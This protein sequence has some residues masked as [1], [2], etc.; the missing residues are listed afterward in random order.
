MKVL[1]PAALAR[2]ARWLLTEAGPGDWTLAAVERLV[3]VAPILATGADGDNRGLQVVP[4]GD[5]EARFSCGRRCRELVLPVVVLPAQERTAPTLAASFRATVEVLEAALGPATSLGRHGPTGPWFDGSPAWGAP[6]LGW[7]RP[8][9]RTLQLRATD[10]GTVLVLQPTGPSEPWR[11]HAHEWSDPATVGG[12]VRERN[13]P[14]NDDLQTPAAPRARTW[15]QWQA[16]LAR[17]LAR[18]PAETMATGSPLHFLMVTGACA[19]LTL[20]STTDGRL[21]FMAGLRYLQDPN[22]LGWQRRET[23]LDPWVL[24]AG[25]PGTVDG[26]AVAAALVQT[27]RAEKVRAAGRMIRTRDDDGHLVLSGLGLG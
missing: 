15:K 4:P 11:L 23:R 17:W 25:R 1:D 7:R 2:S 5:G 10:A 13:V 21:H 9:D 26:S 22:A 27:L 6:F 8:E 14:Q 3:A 16:M 18:L 19:R 24:Q 20:A 12:Y